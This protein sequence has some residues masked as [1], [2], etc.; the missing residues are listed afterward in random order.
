M[1]DLL[2]D[3]SG[4]LVISNFDFVLTDGLQGLAQRVKQKILCFKG[5]WFFDE[6]IGTEYIDAISSKDTDSFVAILVESIREVEGVKDVVSFDVKIDSTTRELQVSFEV[7]NNLGEIIG[8]T[9]TSNI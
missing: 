5:E 2:L 3:A 9:V 1:K 4:D 7:S 6:N 8:D